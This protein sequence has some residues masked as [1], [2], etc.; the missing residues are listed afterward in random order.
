MYDKIFTVEYALPAGL[1]IY[2]IADIHGYLAILDVMHEEIARDLLEGDAPQK[3]LIIYL[4]DY[5]DRGPQSAG[6]IKRLIERQNRGDGISKVFLRGNHEIGMLD[7][8]RN[9]YS[10][11]GSV[12][13]E[14]G[15]L[16]TLLSYGI[17]IK[18]GI[19]LPSEREAVAKELFKV[20][21]PE[22]FAFFNRLES[23]FRIGGYF[24]THAG[25]DP[26]MPLNKQSAQDLTCIREPFLSWNKPLEM[27]V[28]HGHS[29]VP[30]PVILPHRI[31]IDTG[32]YISLTLTAAVLEGNTVRFIQ[33][34]A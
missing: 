2:A 32:I 5:I 13:L 4:G 25:V 17:S 3:V 12:W 1:R 14:W 30:E 22:H 31:G 19:F 28:V 21:P 20:M 33:A 10:G 8:M 23:C 7:F 18:G 34:R 27:M 9:P 11:N 6:V 15:G 16:E 26:N 29:I 24:F